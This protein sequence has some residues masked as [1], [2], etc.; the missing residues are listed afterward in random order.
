VFGTTDVRFT[1]GPT[2]TS[3]RSAT[4]RSVVSVPV[5][6]NDDGDTTMEP[7]AHPGSASA[8]VAANACG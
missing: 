8:V 4:A 6:Q 2:C 1:A 5:L 3:C 7:P